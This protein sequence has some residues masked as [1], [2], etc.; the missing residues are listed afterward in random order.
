MKN[1]NEFASQIQES[2]SLELFCEPESPIVCFRY[3]ATG[4]GTELINE[5]NVKIREGL[6]KK[7]KILFNYST[8]N[9]MVYLRCVLMNPELSADGIRNIIKKV[10]SRGEELTK[11]L[12]PNNKVVNG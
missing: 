7:G 8:V 12:E 4:A 9:G 10:K 5:I 2:D 11:E 6:F 1:T 3:K